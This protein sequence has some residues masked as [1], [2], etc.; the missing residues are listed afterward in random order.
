MFFFLQNSPFLK[1][2]ESRGKKGT[3]FQIPDPDPQHSTQRVCYQELEEELGPCLA[4]FM[5]ATYG[6]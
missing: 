2:A 4:V 6:D 3:G 5:L 1:R